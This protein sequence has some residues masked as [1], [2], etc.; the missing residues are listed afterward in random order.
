MFI[1]T[2]F[3]NPINLVDPD[4]RWPKLPSWK[5]TKAGLK[6]DA[7]GMYVNSGIKH[8]VDWF[9]GKHKYKSIP[10]YSIEVVEPQFNGYLPDRGTPISTLSRGTGNADI[11]KLQDNV[12][13]AFKYDLPEGLQNTGD[14]LSYAGY[15]LT[16]TGIGA[17]IGIPAAAVG[18]AM[19]TIGG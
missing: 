3:N 13:E 12:I 14:A 6:R 2:G 9:Q 15:A 11:S 18:S 19:S 7:Q 5:E 10:K 4:G 16:A 17:E 8:A 1:A